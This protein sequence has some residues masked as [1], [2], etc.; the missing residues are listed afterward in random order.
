MVLMDNSYFIYWKGATNKKYIFSVLKHF[1]SWSF[2]KIVAIF[3]IEIIKKGA[4]LHFAMGSILHRYATDQDS[5]DINVWKRP[6]AAA[7][8]KESPEQH[9]WKPRAPELEPCSW[10]EEL[11]CQKK[12]CS[13]V[14]FFRQLRT[15]E[16]N[17]TVAEHRRSRV[18]I[19]GISCFSNNHQRLS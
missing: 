17:H 1:L 14:S 16:I 7:M 2:V 15:P 18:K 11:Q 4:H 9:S 6:E 12:S 13:A 5:L 3:G 10:K 19:Q 8:K